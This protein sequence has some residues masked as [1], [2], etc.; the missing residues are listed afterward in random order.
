MN[1]TLSFPPVFQNWQSLPVRAGV[2]FGTDAEAEEPAS[3]WSLDLPGD[4]DA[5]TEALAQA[6]A[7]LRAA[8]A[9]LETAP[10]RLEE[11]VSRT[12]AGG[13][14]Q[15]AV[16]VAAGEGGGAPPAEAVLLPYLD[17]LQP[18]RASFGL[19]D[20]VGE[21]VERFQENTRGLLDGMQHLASVE[22]RMEGD[23]LARTLVDWT[24][25]QVTAWEATLT[26][27]QRSLHERSLAMALASRF[28]MIKMVSI[29]AQGAAKIATLIAAPGGALLALPAAWK[30]LNMLMSQ[31]QESES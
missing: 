19:R 29:A 27:E 18:G 11:F 30:Y 15:F 3:R 31:M 16:G 8:Q 12:Q 9:A 28:A 4:P 20:E 10:Q 22:T 7:Q 13:G 23:L 21:L 1:D 24:G 14:A 17:S 25:D 6:E 26:P 2:S 5:A